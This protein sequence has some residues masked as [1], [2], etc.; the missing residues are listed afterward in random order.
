MLPFEC[1][2]HHEICTVP[3]SL[4]CPR[5][6]NQSEE[7]I[8]TN[9]HLKLGEA[10]QMSITSAAMKIAGMVKGLKEEHALVWVTNSSRAAGDTPLLMFGFG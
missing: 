4:L 9:L 10:S 6:I 5:Q 2:A 1:D 3:S 8:V 7:E